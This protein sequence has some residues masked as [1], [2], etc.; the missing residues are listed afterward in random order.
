ML[1]GL[2]DWLWLGVVGCVGDCVVGFVA[3]CCYL[4]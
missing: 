2:V 1:F 3:D 4:L